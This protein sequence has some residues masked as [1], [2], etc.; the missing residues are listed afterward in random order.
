MTQIPLRPAR[1]A[2]LAPMFPPGPWVAVQAFSVDRASQ[3]TTCPAQHH[4]CHVLRAPLRPQEQPAPARSV[5]WVS[6]TTTSTRPLLA[7]AA[8]LALLLL[9]LTSHGGRL[10]M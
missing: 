1:P 3:T 9:H 6:M 2:R 4:V 10:T 7:G 5:R 8:Q